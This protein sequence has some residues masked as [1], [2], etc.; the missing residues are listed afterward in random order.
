MSGWQFW[1]RG[2]REITDEM[3]LVQRRG[4]YGGRAVRTSCYS[5]Q[6][7]SRMHSRPR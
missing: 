3:R 2:P 6:R 7:V 1:N 4:K 5:T